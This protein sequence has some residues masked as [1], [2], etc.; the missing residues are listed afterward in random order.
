VFYEIEVVLEDAGYPP[1]FRLAEEGVAPRIASVAIVDPV[2]EETL[3]WVVPTSFNSIA[4]TVEEVTEEDVDEL[5]DAEPI[6]P[7]E[8]LPPSDPRHRAAIEARDRLSETAFPELQQFT[9]GTV[10]P[11][12]K[13]VKPTGMPFTLTPGKQYALAVI[14]PG[15]HGALD[16]QV[17]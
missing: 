4:A 13:Q 5:A 1:R 6:D 7:I 2:L 14:G 10:P 15:G 17:K 9:Y 16:F 8:D 3:W 11:G 12:F